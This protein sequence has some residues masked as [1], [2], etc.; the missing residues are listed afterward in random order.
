MNISKEALESLY[1]RYNKKEYIHP[2]PLEF[3]YHYKSIGEREIVGL[4]ASS[5][6]YGRVAQILKSVQ[7]V[8]DVI[9]PSPFNYLA[10]NDRKK[11]RNDFKN[12]QHRFTTGK[13]MADLLIGIKIAIN[14]YGSLYNCFLKGLSENDTTIIPALT[15]FV[16][17]L[18]KGAGKSYL[19]LLPSPNKKSA[20]KRL[21]LYLRW[22]VRSDDVDPGGWKRLPTS[23][24]IIPLDTHMHN[25]G[26][27]LGLTN[28]K[29]GNLQTAI[30]ITEGFSKIEPNDPTKY[31][32]CL[33]RLGIRSDANIDD[34]FRSL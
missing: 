24:L 12:F 23:K 10:L 29:Q 11:I 30:D 20:C 13:D 31:D 7:S 8:L 15:A 18:A 34:F 14:N 16:T 3:L 22:M 25:I 28:R 33:T 9:S 19:S 32:F 21:N 5:L 2:D 27:R 26:T 6:A 1:N 4:V 17:T